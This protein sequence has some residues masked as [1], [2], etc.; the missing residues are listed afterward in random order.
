MIVLNTV[1]HQCLKMK[2]FVDRSIETTKSQQDGKELR[3][4]LEGTK[5]SKPTWC[6][7][8]CPL[9]LPKQWG[10]CESG[11]PSFALF[12]LC[13]P[14]SVLRTIPSSHMTKTGSQTIM[15]VAHGCIA[16][17]RI[18]MYPHILWL[19]PNMCLLHHT[20]TFH[21]NTTICWAHL[22]VR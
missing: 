16:C 22:P 21:C 6:H 12:S 19:Q 20:M 3:I 4:G 18:G 8:H 5:L 17:S 11:A 14:C 9:G 13:G 1:V 15:S 7:W 2:L 10:L